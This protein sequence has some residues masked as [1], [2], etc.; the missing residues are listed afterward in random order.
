MNVNRMRMLTLVLAAMMVFTVFTAICAPASSATDAEIEQAITDGLAWLIAQQNLNPADPDYGSWNAYWGELEAG[1]GLALYKL[2]ERAYEL[3][4]DSPFDPDYKYHQN[5]MDGFNWTFANLAIVNITPQDHT[6]GATGT[7]DDPDTNGNGVGVCAQQGGSE[8]YSTGI[9]LAAIAASGTPNR[10][11]NVPGPVSG[12]T[13]GQVAQD[14]VDYLAYGQVDP[15]IGPSGGIHE[16]GW[17]YRAVDNGTGAYWYGDQSNSGYAVLGL[18][19][20]EDFGSTVPGWVKTELDVWIDWVQDDVTGDTN[21]GGS[22]YSYPGDGIGVNILKTGN[23]IFEMA[24]VGDNPTVQRVTNATD[25]LVPHWNDACGS[26]TPA[27]WN[28]TPAQYQTMFTTMKGLEYMGIDTFDGIDWFEDFSDV[29]VAQQDKTAG[30]TYGS[31]QSSCGRGE[32]VIITEWA[33]LTLEKVAPPPPAPAPVPALTPLGILALIGLTG[34]VLVV[35]S[36]GLRQRK[37]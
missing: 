32:P 26:N 11:V 24:F 9:L 3:G 30:P 28:G 14:M 17:D 4:Y 21:D 29:I 19:E 1:T 31:W 18:A 20:A 13:Y 2:C 15:A 16:G 8:T 6:T 33:L 5:V 36:L 7:V 37:E 23:L 34:L 12:W 22:W 27:G 35:G 10:V 25:Y